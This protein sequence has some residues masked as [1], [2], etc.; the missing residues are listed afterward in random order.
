V[1]FCTT[2]KDCQLLP[3]F[4]HSS[5]SE[6]IGCNAWPNL[7]AGNHGRW[8]QVYIWPYPLGE[9]Q[10]WTVRVHGW[11]SWRGVG[12]GGW[13]HTGGSLWGSSQDADRWVSRDV[14][15]C[16][17]SLVVLLCSPPSP[18]T[19]VLPTHTDTYQELLQLPHDK[20]SQFSPLVRWVD[21][22]EL[23]CGSWGLGVAQCGLEDGSG[24]Q[25][26]IW[27][28]HS[29]ACIHPIPTTHSHPE[30][31]YVMQCAELCDDF[32]EDLEFHFFFGITNLMV[33]GT[34]HCMHLL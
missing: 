29:Y 26:D 22:T 27:S 8:L 31:S 32:H 2:D 25:L 24:A 7:T 23:Y 5:G 21:C 33:S 18:P 15:C 10:A 20:L 11:A 13:G 12:E 17:I 9:L 3:L 6:D 16:T 34:C 14:D 4:S 28:L 1:V 30:L 19:H